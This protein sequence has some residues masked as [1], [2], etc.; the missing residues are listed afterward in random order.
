MGNLLQKA[1]KCCREEIAAYDLATLLLR[2]PCRDEGNYSFN[3]LIEDC[4]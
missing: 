2:F 3:Q 4:W 1:R